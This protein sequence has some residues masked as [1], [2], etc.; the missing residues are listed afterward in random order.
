MRAANSSYYLQ[1]LSLQHTPTNKLHAIPTAIPP[2]KRKKLG[3]RKVNLLKA[4]Q[5][6]T[7]ANKTRTMICYSSDHSSSHCPSV[8][9]DFTFTTLFI[10]ISS[11]STPLPSIRLTAFVNNVQQVFLISFFVAMLHTTANFMLLR[12]SSH[13]TQPSAWNFQRP[14]FTKSCLNALNMSPPNLYVKTLTLR[15]D[16]IRRWDFWRA[17]L[18]RSG[19][20]PHEGIPVLIRDPTKLSHPIHHVGT[21]QACTKL[22]AMNQ[23]EG[24]HQNMTM[25]APR[26]LTSQPLTLHKIN[27]GCL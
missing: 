19:W 8:S 11:V 4:T 5:K 26:F 23:E 16:D 20:N 27:F 17:V 3:H 22:L 1:R 24:P 25:L 10:P 7:E 14:V 18:R 6:L 9:V 15:V 13:H 2:H 12:H 21:Q